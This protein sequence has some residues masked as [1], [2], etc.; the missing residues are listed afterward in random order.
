MKKTPVMQRFWDKV[1]FTSDCWEWQS[2]IVGGYP[3]IF[4]NGKPRAA[5]HIT[6]EIYSQKTHCHKGHEFSKQNTFISKIGSRNCRT[7]LKIRN[8]LRPRKSKGVEG[9]S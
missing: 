6:Y 7:C 2:A 1:L 8:D 5:H 4:V 9:L 3:K